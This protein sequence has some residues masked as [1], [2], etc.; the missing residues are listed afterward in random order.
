MESTTADEIR[1]MDPEK[2]H[3][4]T[5]NRSQNCKV[6]GRTNHEWEHSDLRGNN[7][8]GID[9]YSL[10]ECLGCDTVFYERYSWDENDTSYVK[11]KNGDEHSVTFER[12]TTLPKPATR[13]TPEWSDHIGVVDKSLYQ[14]LNE[15]YRAYEQECYILTA[16]GLR[17]ALDLTSELVEI[18]P[19]ITFAEKLGE[20]L[21][22]GYIGETERDLLTVLTNAGSAAAH[23]GWAPSKDETE[24][25]L[26]VLETFIQRVIVNGKRALEMESAIPPRVKRKKT[27]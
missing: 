15:T 2:A 5:C 1:K 26:G 25:L 24:E 4:P 8:W 12:K 16:I 3:C 6:H 18:D 21:E 13:P 22:K 7:L 19:A 20:L 9:R 10:F 27:K 14:I 17:T 11:D 23:R